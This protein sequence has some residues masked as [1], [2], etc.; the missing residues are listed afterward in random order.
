MLIREISDP[1]LQQI[2]VTDVKVDRELAFADVYVSAIEG[3]ERS[4]EVLAG[5]KSASGFHAPCP[6]RAHRTAHLSAPALSL[7][8][9]ARKCRPY[10]KDTCPIEREKIITENIEARMEENIAAEIKERLGA[11]QKILI[12]RTSGRM[13]MRLDP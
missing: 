1:R 6:G 11:A 3:A 8:S 5:L 13:V 2:F 4:E 12:A 10:R 7:G 9:N